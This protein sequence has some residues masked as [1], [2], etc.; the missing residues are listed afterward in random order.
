MAFV[1]RLRWLRNGADDERVV[2]RIAEETKNEIV[3]VS[4]GELLIADGIF[5]HQGPSKA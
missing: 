4:L 5:P 2:D 3:T 1:H